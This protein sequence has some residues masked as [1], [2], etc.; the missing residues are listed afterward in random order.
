MPN[1]PTTASQALEEEVRALQ[2]AG[3]EKQRDMDSAC[4]R[5]STLAIESNKAAKV[6]Q[7]QSAVLE[8]VVAEGEASRGQLAQQLDT[9]RREVGATH[10]THRSELMVPNPRVPRLLASCPERRSVKRGDRGHLVLS[11]DRDALHCTD[12]R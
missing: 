12:I 7:S 5:L 10:A 4:E 3:A 2:E 1:A 11:H 6:A 9:L 8:K